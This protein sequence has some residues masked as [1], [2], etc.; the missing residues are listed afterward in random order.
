MSPK[1]ILD[2][3]IQVEKEKMKQAK[4]SKKDLIILDRSFVSTLAFSFANKIVYSGTMEWEE[5][6]SFLMNE[7]SQILIPEVIFL[8][9]TTI[10][11]SLNRSAQRGVDIMRDK[12]WTDPK[13][14]ES[15]MKFYE[16]PEFAQLLP[17]VRVIEIDSENMDILVIYDKILGIIKEYEY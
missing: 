17:G 4:L 12:F 11:T 8:F 14:L 16:S 9:K 7:R 3:Y 6:T 1:Q 15:F 13:F 10:R 5:N 2:A